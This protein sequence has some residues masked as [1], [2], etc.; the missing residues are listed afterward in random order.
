[1]TNVR[2]ALFS[3]LVFSIALNGFG[4]LFFVANQSI[5]ADE[6]KSG[7]PQ[8]PKDKKDEKPTVDKDGKPLENPFPNR[9]PAPQLDGGKAWLNTS[10]E[11]TKKD[12]RGKVVILDFWTYCC[13]NCIH[14][15][16]D[17]K[18]LE[19][20]YKNE[21]VVIGV[22]S[23]KFDNEKDTEAIRRAIVRYEIEHPVINDSEMTVWRKFGANSWPTIVLMDP[24]G[25]YCGFVSGEGNRELLDTLVGKLVEYHKA[26]GTLDQTPV[27]FD[28]ERTKL[29][30]GP[31][32]FPGKLLVDEPNDRIFISDSN[33][34]R[35]VVSSLDGKLI[36]IIGSG[37][38]GRK[39][40]A[41]TEASFDHPQGMELVGNT[42]YVADT[43]NH[44]LR[45][46]DLKA[47]VV[48]TLAGTGKQARFRARGGAL[49]TTALNSPWDLSVVDGVLYI[50]M[51]GPHQVWSHK[52]GSDE[53]QVHAGSGREDIIDGLLM[54]S[55][56]AQPSGITNDGEFLYIADS[57]G[58]AIRK[59]ATKLDGEVSTVVGTH[60]LPSGRALF[61]FGDVDG[62]S[63]ETRLQHPL[64][65]EFYKGKLYV[66]DAYN[67]KIKIVDPKTRTCKTLFG[68]GEAGT[69]LAPLR[70][71]EPAGIAFGKGKMFIADTNNHRIVVVDIEAKTPKPSVFEVV[72]LTAP[73][74]KHEST[75]DDTGIKAVTVKSQKVSGK[76]LKVDVQLKYPVEYKI[77]TEFPTRWKLTGEKT[78]KLIPPDAVGKRLKGTL[79]D[80]TFSFEIPLTETK[81][82]STFQ[83][84]VIYSYCRG[85]KSGLCKFRTA[86]FNL[87]LEV[88]D[89]GASSIKLVTDTPK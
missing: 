62:D 38:M 29:K 58:S 75:D 55:A 89:G 8:D 14:V 21:L 23:A 36:D 39:D 64:H 59:I 48:S 9:F 78:Q 34:N 45:T 74:V 15:L 81:G 13:I 83:L 72:G 53:L 30:S 60:D 17:L 19:K 47:K 71:H 10:G 77:N 33:H 70:I 7:P 84:T 40:G 24:E 66:A 31:L 46:V 56:L 87:P 42:L 32:K 51:A 2:V 28:L 18:F 65:V 22:H 80:E 11:I 5:F 26:K 69:R 44:L 41:F 86:K 57:E 82:K 49:K 63:K 68:D 52:L 1:M 35:I 27:R 20:K 25:N 16:P 43:E 3:A 54:Q 6:K 67:H 4:D 85:G 88:A 73:V 76:M 37:A 50:A 61:E 12:L 79:A